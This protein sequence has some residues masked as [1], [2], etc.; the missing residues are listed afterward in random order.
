VLP[1]DS[2]E[3]I[4]VIQKSVEK[5]VSSNDAVV[6]PAKSAINTQLIACLTRFI[7][8][9]LRVLQNPESLSWDFTGARGSAQNALLIGGLNHLF[10]NPTLGM[11]KQR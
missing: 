10:L 2:R 9:L 7:P 4:I 5:P 1:H 11:P 6:I 3:A 8:T